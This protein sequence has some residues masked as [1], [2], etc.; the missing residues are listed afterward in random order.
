MTERG[1]MIK[2]GKNYTGVYYRIATSGCKTFYIVYRINGTQVWDRIGSELE[3]IT[4]TI[5]QQARNKILL[6]QLSQ[7]ELTLDEAVAKHHAAIA[8]DDSKEYVSAELSR[9]NQWLKPF[10]GGKGMNEI[11]VEEIQD[12]KSKML[13]SGLSLAY[14]RLVLGQLKRIYNRMIKWNLYHGFN[15]AAALEFKR[16]DR[17]RERALTSEEA[18]SLLE[19]LSRQN[20]DTYCRAAFAVY[21]GL[22]SKEISNLTPSDIDLE[23]S[24]IRVRDAKSATVDGKVRHAIFPQRL[25]TVIKTMYEDHSYAGDELLF[26]GAMNYKSFIKAVNML[27]LNKDKNPMDRL[28]FHG[29]RH[30]HASLLGKMGAR[31]KDVQNQLGHADLKTSERYTHAP[32]E[33]GRQFVQALGEKFDE[34]VLNR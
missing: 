21:A 19:E 18:V 33:D 9:Y 24:V 30:T 23:A 2:A 4:A 12:I 20:N 5:A 15:P 7:R 31:G 11:T 29:L 8:T 17:K 25:S 13:A 16:S 1:K 6:G 14:S 3:N 22:R 28:T 10:L 26:K 34:A 32:W 27:S